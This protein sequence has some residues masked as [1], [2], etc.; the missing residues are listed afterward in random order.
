[1][2]FEMWLKWK[3]SMVFGLCFLK[4]A[5]WGR[6]NSR[7]IVWQASFTHKMVEEEPRLIR[8]FKI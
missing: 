3:R 8:V 7:H 5:G 1:M 6:T 4:L 2:K